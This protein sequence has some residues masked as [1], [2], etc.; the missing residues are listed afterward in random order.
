MKRIIIAIALVAITLMI[1]VSLAATHDRADAATPQPVPP[2]LDDLLTA[3]AYKVPAFG[4]M[5]IGENGVL[6]VYLLDPT[7]AAAAKKAISEVFGPDVLKSG[8]NAQQGRY[9]FLQLGAWYGSAHSL[10]TDDSDINLLDIDEAANRLVIGIAKKEATPQV[11]KML[12]QLGIPREAVIIEV[13]EI[14]SYTHTLQNT[15]G[16]EGGLQIASAVIYTR[17]FSAVDSSGRAGFVTNSHCTNPSGDVD[18]V[19]GSTVFF[20][21][22]I[23]AF[24][25]SRAGVEVNDPPFSFRCDRYGG[26]VIDVRC[27]RSDAAFIQYDDGV[28]ALAAGYIARP[29]SQTIAAPVLTISHTASPFR[30]TGKATETL[31][32]TTLHKVGRTTGWTSGTVSTTCA[33]VKAISP[34]SGNSWWL[35]CQYKART[36]ASPPQVISQTGDS[37]SPV[38]ARIGTSDDVILHGILWGG[39]RAGTRFVFSPISGVEREL[40]TLSVCAVP[41]SC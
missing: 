37:G 29:T 1:S 3:V 6:Q 8:M 17:G 21:P 33:Q 12:A 32:G 41:Y 7:Q 31:S 40:G 22:G 11:E 18:G 38:F 19:M 39:N 10:I 24:G 9:G 13:D 36:V 16:N 25:G 20:E 15:T 28:R 30:I 23:P 4:G 2:T 34:I 14:L 27:R 5:Y 26:G 35:K